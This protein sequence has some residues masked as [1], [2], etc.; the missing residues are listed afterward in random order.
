M[1]DQF[2]DYMGVVIETGYAPLDKKLNSH[3]CYKGGGGGGTTT[4]SSGI[5]EEFR[6]YVERGLADAETLRD[7]GK[8]SYVEGLTPEQKESQEMQLRL[9]R[10]TL[11]GIAEKSA[12]ARGVLEQA[13]RGEGIYGTSGYGTVAQEMAP[14][15]RQI[16]D[17]TRGTGQ[18][19][20]AMG[21]ALGSAKQQAMIEGGVQDAV[22]KNV[23]QELSA[24]R[25]GQ[26]GAAKDVIGSG[27]DVGAQYGTGA[28][29][30]ERVGTTLQQQ[31]QREGDADY[32]GI[33]RFFGLL[34]SPAVG[35]ESKTTQSSGGGK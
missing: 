18:T 23:A 28:A 17:I 3:I 25:A 26:T 5:P 32:Q 20:A 35:Q 34:G 4:S 31:G 16:A 22:I 21:G 7:E 12:Q 9:G 24:R 29:A 10:E 13:S 19:Q 11:P 14:Q 6:P 33:Q 27:Q 15:L 30:I 8:L 1:I 2:E